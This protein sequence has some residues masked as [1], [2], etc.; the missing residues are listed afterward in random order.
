MLA[1]QIDRFFN[2]AVDF[3]K[4][5]GQA[6]PDLDAIEARPVQEFRLGDIFTLV[7]VDTSAVKGMSLGVTLDNKFYL[8]A[9]KRDDESIVLRYSHE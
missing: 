9:S 7:C 5:H 1:P 4:N 2:L 6:V 8:L 3:I